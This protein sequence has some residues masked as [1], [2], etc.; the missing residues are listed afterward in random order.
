MPVRLR[1]KPFAAFSSAST[2]MDRGSDLAR[3]RQYG[4]R[5]AALPYWP[6]VFGT[7]NLPV[8]AWTVAILMTALVFWAGM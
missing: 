6:A 5:L 8:L 3:S 4:V 2:S 7:A 1:L